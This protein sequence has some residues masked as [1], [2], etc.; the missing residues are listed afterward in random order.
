MAEDTSSGERTE[1]PS[2]KRRDDYRKKGQVAQSREVQTAAL[3]TLLLLFWIFFAPRFWGSLQELIVSVWRT[4]GTYAVTASSLMQLAYHLAAGMAVLLLPLFLTVLV[5]GF[6]ATYLQIGW[7][8]TAQP[9]LPDLSKLDPI[10]GMGRFFSKRS[11][12]ELIK[13]LAKVGLIGWVAYRT[14]AGE[15]D[16]ALLLGEMPVADTV[17]Y[18][19]QTTA[20]VMAKVA[21]V[22]I[23]ETEA[24]RDTIWTDF[25]SPTSRGP[26]TVAPPRAWTSRVEMAAEW[27]AGMTRTLASA[28]R[29]M[30]G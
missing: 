2:A 24:P 23:S 11:L 14:V 19:A 4:S 9:L 28:D 29:R 20:L 12:V 18:L 13:S 17:R 27:M 22:M 6:L 30:K 8:F 15:F 26:I 10:R 21:A 25:S 16:E 7:L 1:S 5:I 3:F